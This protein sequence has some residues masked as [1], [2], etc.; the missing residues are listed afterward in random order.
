MG[1]EA[2]PIENYESLDSE[3]HLYSGMSLHKNSTDNADSYEYFV[4][5]K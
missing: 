5:I 2:L 1:C 4:E 3:N